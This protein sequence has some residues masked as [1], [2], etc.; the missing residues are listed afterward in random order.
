MTVELSMLFWSTALMIVQMLI[1]VGLVAMQVGLVP[2][3][4]NR[5]GLAEVTGMAGRAGRAHRNMAENMVL[6]AALVMVVHL[7]GMANE[8][9]ALGA[10]IFF[11]ARLVYAVVYLAG[12]PWLR[13][14]VWLVSFAGLLIVASP[15][16]MG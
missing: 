14:G 6:F 2:L 1:A 16:V 10:Q 9:T 13:T 8:M 7:G 12:I 5:E 15:M 4:S 11:F 3:A